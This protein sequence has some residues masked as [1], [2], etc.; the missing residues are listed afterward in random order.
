MI[1]PLLMLLGSYFLAAK[2][3]YELNFKIINEYFVISVII[4]AVI[5]WAPIFAFK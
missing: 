3:C 1:F 5:S 4:I 2:Y